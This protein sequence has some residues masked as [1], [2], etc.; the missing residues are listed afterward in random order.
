MAILDKHTFTCTKFSKDLYAVCS[1]SKCTKYK[2]CDMQIVMKHIFYIIN[3]IGLKVTITKELHHKTLTSPRKHACNHV[4][5]FCFFLPFLFLL[6]M[7]L[8]FLFLAQPA[9]IPYVCSVVKY[10]QTYYLLWK[11]KGD[12]NMMTQENQ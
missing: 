12:S 8:F 6:L 2:K 5:A 3:H 7:L 10:M 11:I 4:K 9:L 1:T